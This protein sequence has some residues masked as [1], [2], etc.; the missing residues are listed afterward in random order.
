MDATKPA[1]V[2][3]QGSLGTLF[4]VLLA[5][6]GHDVHVVSSRAGE[7]KRVQ[8]SVRGRRSLDAEVTLRGD[9]PDQPAW[10]AM[11]ASRAEDAVERSRMALKATGDD[12]AIAPVHN[13]L[14]SLDVVDALG[15]DRVIP[16]VVGFNARM[17]GPQTVELT[18]KGGIKTGALDPSNEPVVDELV[19]S[20]LGPIPAHRTDN[21]RGAVWSKWCISCAINGLA[22]VA[23][24]G[25]GPVT[26]Q[27]AG[28]EALL[29]IV[30]ECVQLAEAEEIEL[31]RVAGPFAPDTLAGRAT[32]GLGGAFRRAVVWLIGRGYEGVVPSSLDALRDGRDPELET[33]TGT[34]VELGEEHDIA[35]PWNKS[36]LE[37]GREIVGGK[38]EASMANLSPLRQR[39]TGR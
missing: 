22:V 2:V 36:V 10:L 24:A 21:P 20:L 19:S 8:L 35:T 34:A 5:D 38:R 1:L 25:V 14:V 29:S 28:R 33:I 4:S 18:S 39:A 26:R 23:G 3:G 27:R 12:G 30:T 15:P 9:L 32:S 7:P 37:F 17:R 13:G 6:A 31:T 11:V 16:V